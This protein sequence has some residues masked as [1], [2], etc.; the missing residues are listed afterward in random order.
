MSKIQ[1][2]L[3]LEPFYGGSH[4]QFIETLRSLS[5]NYEDVLVKSMQN[6]LKTTNSSN[7]PIFEF[8]LYEMKAKKWHWRS[9][10]SALY[11]AQLIDQNETNFDI[12]FVSSILNLTELL[13]LRPDLS[14]ISK[15]IIYFHENQLVYPIQIQK[16]RD[17]QYG[18]N[19]ILSCLV[20]DQVIF[21]SNFNRNS[22]I[23][24]IKPFLK[25][26]PD[27]RPPNLDNLIETISK[28]SRVLYYP[29]KFDN[30]PLMHTETREK[31]ILHIIWPHRWEHDKDPESFFRI[32]F[33]L[34]EQNV[35]FKV[36][37]LGES[38]SQIPAIFE[39]AKIKLGNVILN[40]G[41]SN[42]KEEYYKILSTANV[43]ISTAIH[44]FFGVSML[45]AAYCGC[46]PLCPSRLVYPE[47]FPTQYLY[48][49]EDE[50]VEKLVK[51]AN[52]PEQIPLPLDIAFSTIDWTYSRDAYISL[53]SN[54]EGDNEQDIMNNSHTI[55]C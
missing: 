10:T 3:I 42:S 31:A 29:I 22:F 55:K 51:F 21:N 34:K 2:V 23:F 8:K 49:T 38:F 47:L 15:K 30:I 53:F 4:K 36:S 14:R 11:M 5:V 18:Y 54:N 19:Q 28:K 39:E 35:L 17:F 6:K 41:Y 32:L 13:A 45:E 26:M 33:K 50:C 12:L 27:Y 43:A 16:E 52:S 44:E 20:A 48:N 40:W 37:V 25:M 46:Y 1:R 9:R 7:M 24:A